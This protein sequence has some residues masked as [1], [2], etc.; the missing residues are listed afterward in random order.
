MFS[1]KQSSV[2]L[3]TTKAVYIVAFSASCEAIWLRKL[4]SGLFDMELDT[5]VILCDNQICIK[6][7]E[8]LLFHD[9]SK[10]I[11]IQYFY[12]RNMVQKGAIKIQY[13]STDEKVANVLTKPLSRVMFE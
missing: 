9:K 2:A 11:E 1:K 6:M 13:V 3:S 12:I 5:T 8:N 10:H 4:M 7:T